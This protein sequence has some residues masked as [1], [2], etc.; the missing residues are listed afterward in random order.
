MTDK[1]ELLAVTTDAIIGEVLTEAPIGTEPQESIRAITLG[2]FDAINAHPWVG[3]Y[4]AGEPWQSAMLQIFEAI[5]KQLQALGVPERIL[6]DAATALLNYV[7]GLA[8]QYAAAA[9][10]LPD[11]ADRSTV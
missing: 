2:V 4:L 11:N 7:L 5:G 8:G 1:G 6:F 10:L 3:A 9:R